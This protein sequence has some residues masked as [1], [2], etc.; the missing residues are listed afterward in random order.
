MSEIIDTPP[1]QAPK[2]D[3]ETISEAYGGAQQALEALRKSRDG[4]R[5]LYNATRDAKQ[6]LQAEIGQL[7]LDRQFQSKR[8]NDLES[9]A[10]SL[11]QENMQLKDQHADVAL[12]NARLMARIT[13]L[14]SQQ[15]NG[16]TPEAATRGPGR[17][18]KNV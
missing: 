6:A 5:D 15:T 13:E 1:A 10:E 17:P 4:F 16:I 14:E 3:L 18:R 8:V 7:Q 2:S 11:R 9:D 12:E